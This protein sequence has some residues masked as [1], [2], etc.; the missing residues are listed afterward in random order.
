MALWRGS[1]EAVAKLQEMASTRR[2]RTQTKVEDKM[3]VSIDHKLILRTAQ[4]TLIGLAFVAGKPAYAQERTVNVL[5]W[6]DYV[7]PKVLADFTKETGIKVV[8]DTTDSNEMIETKLYAGSSGYD[9]V[10]PSATFLRREVKA[11]VIRELDKAK[12]PNLQHAWGEVYKL[13]AAY[14]A[15][16]SHAANYTWFTTGI[17]Y[18]VD[19]VKERLGDVPINTWDI[20]FNPEKISKLADCGVYFLDSPEDIIPATLRYLGLDPDYSK[21]PRN[22]EKAAEA[23]AKV[24]PYVR[25]FHSSEY[26]NALANG[27]I[28]LAIGWSGDTFQARDRALEAHQNVPDKPLV[29][30]NYV[31]P[32]EGTLMSLDTMAIPKD[33]PHVDEAYAFINF[34]LRPD[35][36][37]RNTNFVKF[38]N[39]V[40]SS[41]SLVD[42]AIRKNPAIYPD[43][44]TMATLFTVQPPDQKQQRIITRTWTRLTTGH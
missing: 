37:A 18:N 29:N 22:I 28:C 30:I 24:R 10:V 23:L 25:K 8:F 2:F 15:S 41:Q 43:E 3:K 1:T 38:A 16:N 5:H 19:K 34:M 13:L 14:D 40:L 26:I 20:V 12:L 27:D 11:G 7:D 31:I 33:A 4:A 21:N 39:G 6:S 42:E 32:T 9:V 36:A 35:I 17:G 44:A